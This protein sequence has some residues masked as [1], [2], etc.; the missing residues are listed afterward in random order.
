MQNS[1]N[2]STS[3]LEHA[4]DKLGQLGIVL[5]IA[6][7]IALVVAVVMRWRGLRWTW[8]LPSLLLIVPV[9][10]VDHMSGF[11]YGCVSVISTMLGARW[12][13]DD[14]RDGAD[15]AANA[16]ARR[17]PGHGARA[18]SGRRALT[19]RKWV[20][21]HGLL[22]GRDDHGRPV[23]IPAHGAPHTLV[24]GATGSG[25]TVTQAWIT[26]RI[27]EAGTGAIVIDPKGDR[28]LR[29]EL[30]T[31]AKRAGREFHEWTPDGPGVYNPFSHGT[32]TEIA[33]K[34]LAGETYTEPH[35]AKH[36]AT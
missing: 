20:T 10:S 8:T 35:Y 25:K 26:A 13:W 4:A 17:G 18:L 34:A 22:V 5:G 24:V 33:D 15:L 30:H 32:A 23:R 3:Q 1:S 9:W 27:I 31:A 21:E 28:L 14:M 29:D 19:R 36:S 6:L 2:D 16:R 11:A 12:H 7:A